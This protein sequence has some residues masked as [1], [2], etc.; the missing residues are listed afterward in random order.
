VVKA[1]ATITSTKVKPQADR[2]LPV[3]S[4]RLTDTLFIMRDFLPRG[5]SYRLG[6]VTVPLFRDMR[7]HVELVVGSPPGFPEK[8]ILM[9]HPNAGDVHEMVRLSVWIIAIL[10]STSRD[11]Y[12]TS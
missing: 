12:C 3:T 5:G 1:K 7:P 11:G 2:Q 9:Y 10:D 8:S 4:E 6:S